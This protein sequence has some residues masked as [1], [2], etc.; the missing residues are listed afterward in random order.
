MSDEDSAE[1]FVA[2]LRQALRELSRVPVA[3]TYILLVIV[4]A[5]SATGVALSSRALETSVEIRT[6]MQQAVPLLEQSVRLEERQ[7]MF[8]DSLAKRQDSINT[9]RRRALDSIQ[10]RQP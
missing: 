3:V 6:L 4:L 5:L 7:N 10:G 9:A 2:A 8:W 1:G